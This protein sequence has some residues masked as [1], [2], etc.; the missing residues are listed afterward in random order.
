MS[1]LNFDTYFDYIWKIVIISS[2]LYLYFPSTVPQGFQFHMY[3]VVWWCATI[4]WCLFLFWRFFIY[5]SCYPM[6]FG[7]LIL[8]STF[9]K[10]SLSALFFISDLVTFRSLYI[11]FGIFW[12]SLLN[13][14]IYGLQ[15]WDFFFF[16]SHPAL[17]ILMSVSVWISCN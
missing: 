17:L 7:K 1:F 6:Y 12:M 2:I 5:I 4:Y 16:F 14:W 11:Y 10:L 15:P 3:S 13:F 9:S 8:S